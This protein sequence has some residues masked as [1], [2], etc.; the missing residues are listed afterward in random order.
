MSQ[1][2]DYFVCSE[3]LIE[4]WADALAEQD[5]DLQQKI[6]SEMPRFVTLK[7]IGQDDFNILAR[8]AEGDDVDTVKAVG[9]VDLVR[10][11]SEEEGPWIMA[12]R[13]PAVEAMA[14]MVVNESLI[15][16][17]IKAVAEFNGSGEDWCRE[18][19]TADAAESLKEICELAV[20]ARLGVFICFYG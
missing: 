16:R 3:S 13:Q 18:T 7:N 17:W 19:L 2:F 4:R 10:A 20:E 11:V 6:E 9:E 1:L 8:C 14:R 12:F 15:Q 5:E